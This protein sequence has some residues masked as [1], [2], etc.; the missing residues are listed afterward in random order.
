MQKVEEFLLELPSETWR[1]GQGRA[2]SLGAIPPTPSAELLLEP[3][4]FPGGEEPEPRQR[5]PGSE[6]SL[7]TLSLRG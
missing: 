2:R 7:G 5:K 1:P 4:S 3:P 6:P